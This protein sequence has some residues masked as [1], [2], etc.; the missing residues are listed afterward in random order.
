MEC[1]PRAFPYSI[2]ER[3]REIGFT[4]TNHTEDYLVL[5]LNNIQ[6]FTTYKFNR[7]RSKSGSTLPVILICLD[8]LL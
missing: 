2:L 5:L 6:K 3:S 4:K 8:V 7:F 1:T